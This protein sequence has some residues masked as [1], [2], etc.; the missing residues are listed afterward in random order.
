MNHWRHLRAVVLLPGVVAVVTHEDVPDV[1][2][3]GM[4]QD[5]RLFAKEGVR[6]EGDVVA[7]VAAL[8]PEIAA[9]AAA[10]VEVEYEP[11][12]SIVD[13]EAAAHDA[14][15]L[16][17]DDWEHYEGD[18]SMAREANVVVDDKAFALELRASLMRLIELGARNVVSASWSKQ[19]L[20]ARVLAWLSYGIFR[21]STG[22]LGY[23]KEQENG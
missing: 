8:T 9:R 6:W 22:L 7:G 13:F 3:G 14:S 4:V 15:R 10:L 17:H 18:E 19:P 20:L 16:V 21:V 5:R 23:A 1:R 11:L 2:Y 12:P